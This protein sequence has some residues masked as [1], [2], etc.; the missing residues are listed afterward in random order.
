MSPAAGVL[1]GERR[2]P[3]TERG[4]RIEVR[5]VV[6][7]D[8][9]VDELLGGD[10]RW[11]REQEDANRTHLRIRAYVGDARAGLWSSVFLRPMLAA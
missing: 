1:E 10:D 4:W 3:R 2:E 5:V 7:L 6:G 9:N 11:N 8:Q